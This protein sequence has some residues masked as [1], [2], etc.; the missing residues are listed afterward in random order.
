MRE[1]TIGIARGLYYY[2]YYPMWKK[3]FLELGTKVIVSPPTNKRIMDLGVA[4]S[5][6][7]ICISVKVY[8]GHVKYLLDRNVDFIFVPRIV[9]EEKHKENCPKLLSLPD[10]IRDTFSIEES[11]I[12]SPELYFNWN[13]AKTEEEL[14]KIGVLLSNKTRKEIKS[15]IRKSLAFQKTYEYYLNRGYNTLELYP[16]LTNLKKLKPKK[17]K[18]GILIGIVGFPYDIY[19]GYLNASILDKLKK[20]G[21]NYVVSNMLN[22]KLINRSYKFLNKDL[23]WHQSNVA[24]KAGLYFLSSKDID[25]VITISSFGCGLSAIYT[26]LLD[27]FNKERNK[28]PLIHLVIDEQTGE[29]GILTRLEAFL[30][31]LKIRKGR[32]IYV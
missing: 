32:E 6:D 10:L 20:M 16:R 27:I 3:F 30:D 1:K 29:A 24:L 18:S 12:L 9:S 22:Y 19:D 14:F 26:K 31:L 15:I 11:R 5:V 17:M 8:H 28:K 21:I 7:D 13:R 4:Y 25:G 23:F 2:M